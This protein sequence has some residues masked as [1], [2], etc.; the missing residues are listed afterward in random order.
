MTLDWFL[1]LAAGGVLSLGIMTIYAWQG[2]LKRETQLLAEERKQIAAVLTSAS[3]RSRQIISEAEGV[4]RELREDITL[5]ADRLVERVWQ[6][7]AQEFKKG[8]EDFQSLIAQAAQKDI[9]RFQQELAAFETKARAEAQARITR[10]IPKVVAKLA[11]KTLPVEVQ[12]DLVVQAVA[13]AAADG[14][15]AHT[16]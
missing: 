6:A 5:A 10:L 16:V 13:A 7:Y 15:F 9:A 14:F 8:F 1:G 11:G 2:R 3:S 4:R 12:E